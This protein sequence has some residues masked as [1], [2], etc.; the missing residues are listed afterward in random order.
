MIKEIDNLNEP[1]KLA[2]KFANMVFVLWIVFSILLIVYAFY[3]IFN[4]PEPVS[5][6]FYILSIM[7]KL[8]F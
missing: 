6:V 2:I 8:L 3:K 5:P 4:P 1:P 7:K